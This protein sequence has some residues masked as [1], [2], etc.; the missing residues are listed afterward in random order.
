MQA[1]MSMDPVEVWQ[2]LWCAHK[3]VVDAVLYHFNH[4]DKEL[5][6]AAACI[7]RAAANARVQEVHISEPVDLAKLSELALHE[8]FPDLRVIKINDNPYAAV[9]TSIADLAV[10]TLSKLSQL[11]TFDISSCSQ[12]L[13]SHAAQSLKE[14]CKQLQTLL[15]PRESCQLP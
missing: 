5:L 15:L 7:S 4:N 13:A 9:V 1:I 12:L 6:R 3:D 2:A 8:R 10:V 14:F 11:V